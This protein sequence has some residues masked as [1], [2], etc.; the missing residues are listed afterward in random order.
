MA[1]TK[2]PLSRQKKAL[3]LAGGDIVPRAYWVAGISSWRSG[4]IDQASV[5]MHLLADL[6]NVQSHSL[7]SA[8]AYWASRADLRAGNANQSITYLTKAARY[9][10]T[11]YGM[12]AAEAW[13]RISPL[14]FHCPILI[15]I[16]ST[17]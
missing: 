5:Y 2:K 7:A 3:K 13:V 14:I 11:F 12:L 15:R 6:D 4:Y 1:K 8:G 9:Q 17:G 16:I 10:D